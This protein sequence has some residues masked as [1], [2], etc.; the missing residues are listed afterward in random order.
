MFLHLMFKNVFDFKFY[1][2]IK[3]RQLKHKLKYL[4]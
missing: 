1:L 4:K 3:E 2:G